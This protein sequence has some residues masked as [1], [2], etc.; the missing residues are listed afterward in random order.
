MRGALKAPGCIACDTACLRVAYYKTYILN[1]DGE[2]QMSVYTVCR[3]YRQNIAWL[4]TNINIIFHSLGRQTLYIL[5]CAH[6]QCDKNTCTVCSYY[7][8]AWSTGKVNYLYT[9][10]S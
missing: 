8:S 10:H 3:R 6:V 9:E 1:I 5:G 2:L 4:Y 7:I